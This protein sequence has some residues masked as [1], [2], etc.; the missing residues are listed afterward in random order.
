MDFTCY[1]IFLLIFL[2]EFV[3][4]LKLVPLTDPYS[5]VIPPDPYDVFS[6]MHGLSSLPP[7]DEIFKPTEVRSYLMQIMVSPLGIPKSER[8]VWDEDCK[9]YLLV[10]HVQ[11]S[12]LS[13]YI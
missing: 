8:A 10:E 4:G 6:E 13:I 5:L 12:N 11:D 1:Y 3:K 9:L 7:Y 2:L